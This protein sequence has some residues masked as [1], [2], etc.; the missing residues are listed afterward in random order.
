MRRI[1]VQWV[2]F[3]ENAPVLKYM[4]HRIPKK[5]DSEGGEDEP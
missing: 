1:G 4:D 3:P 5:E 2:H